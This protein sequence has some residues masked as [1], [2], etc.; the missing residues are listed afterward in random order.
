MRLRTRILRILIV[1]FG[2][3]AFAGYFAFATFF[4]NPLEGDLD[5]DV[6]ALA[7]RD[8]DFFV[9]KA[10]L[11]ET[12]APFP[13]LAIQKQLD[14]HP[15]WQAW[16]ASPEYQALDQEHG[17]EAGLAELK[18]QLA[19]I[20][21]V[22]DVLAVFGGEDLA[23]AG[24]FRGTDLTQV[25]WVVYGRANWKGKLAAAALRH[26][27]LI[28]LEQQGITAKVEERYVTISGGQ[29]P[30]PLCVTR[31]RDVVL[32]ATKPELVLK[33]L[34][35]DGSGYADSLH[36][37]AYYHDHL[38]L[39][40][41][42]AER[43]ELELFVNM[44]KFLENVGFQG[45]FPDTKSQDFTPAFL[46]RLFQVR[47]MKN[48]MGT[49]GFDQGLQIDLHGEFASELVTKDQAHFYQV[50][51]FDTDML[52]S[53]AASWCPADA[54]LFAYAHGDVG[55][56]VKQILQSLDGASRQLI[57]DAFRN[58]G[59]YQNIE[60]VIELLDGAL[61]NRAALIVRKNDYP[62]D[63]QGPKNKTDEP[64]PAV[65][66]VLW[67]SDVKP[68]VKLREDIGQGGQHFGLKGRT[69]TEVGYF[70]YSE[71]GYETREYWSVGV[72]GTGVISTVN[73]GEVTII[74]NCVSMIGNLLKVQSQG[75]PSYPRLSDDERFTAMARSGLKKANVMTWV[76]PQEL[77][78]IL[79]AELRYNN[80]VDL[81]YKSIL[82]MEEQKALRT[83]YG[84]RAKDK[85][86][87][88]EL[89]A[90]DDY[91][92]QRVKEIE[93]DFKA[94]Q[95]PVLEAQQERW[96]TWLEAADPWLMMLSLEPKTWDLMLRMP[97]PLKR[98]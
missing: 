56:T 22:S 70:K 39:R 90:L 36:Q 93:R 19:T 27:G 50:R 21:T 84:G 79:R 94:Q 43:D 49:I 28:G 54:A 66:L 83:K 97:V 51:G 9:A 88:E 89:G 77:G 13:A 12:F 87:P 67:A 61:R 98:P 69:E 60:Q 81:D 44:R 17:I 4:Y 68:I 38:N 64:V 1:L 14:Q 8:V 47:S 73:A 62:V 57:E 42:S 78:P 96:I 72:P 3:L 33:A 55:D 76:N 34:E 25:D 11:S 24:Y 35:L 5:V 15:A 59:K 63:P 75:A 48:A 6:A 7:P 53:E 91:V 16:V 18:Q 40:E 2:V 30:R 65:A 29:L 92:D 41:R 80:R 86:T 82:A 85:L 26:P 52:T 74:T 32:I 95:I 31:I 23:V 20:P 58:T 37:S 45:E 71:A 46:G 10:Q